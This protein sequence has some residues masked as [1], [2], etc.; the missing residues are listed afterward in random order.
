MKTTA[1]I[2][3]GAATIGLAGCVTPK[4][5][6]P[7]AAGTDLRQLHQAQLAVTNK[8][9]TTYALE[10]VP[11]FEGLLRGKLQSLGY[12]LVNTNPAMHLDVTVLACDPG[13][14]TLRTV[15]GFGAGRAVMKFTARFTDANGKLLAELQGGKAYH[16]LET[17][18]NPTFKSDESTRMGLVS[19]SVSQI[20]E[21]IQHNGQSQ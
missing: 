16:G 13:N 21:F 20:G 6:T 17:V 4:A 14:R 8:V 3:L 15:V 18:D 5:T 11:L 12:T 9:D 10:T 2:L 1:L 19:Y 7:A